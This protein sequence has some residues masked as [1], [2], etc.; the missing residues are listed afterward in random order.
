VFALR[1]GQ[2]LS[3]RNLALLVFLRVWT[4]PSGDSSC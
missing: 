1:A 2:K 4:P 3:H